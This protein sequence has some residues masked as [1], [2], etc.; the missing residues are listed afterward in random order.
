MRRRGTSFHLLEFEG[1]S[2]AH[3]GGVGGRVTMERERE[4]EEVSGR[5]DVGGLGTA[6]GA[7]GPES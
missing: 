1:L 2:Q 7:Y 4:R 6:D 3:G 5:K